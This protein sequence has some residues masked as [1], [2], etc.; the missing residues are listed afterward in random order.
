MSPSGLARRSGLDPTTFNKSKRIAREGKPRWPTTES[1]AKILAATDSTLADFVTLAGGTPA[2]ETVSR[3][4]IFGLAQAASEGRVDA[5]GRPS[6]RGQ[7]EIAF[8]DLNDP[9]AYALEVRGNALAPVYRDA[10]VLVVSPAASVRRGDRVVV[11]TDAGKVMV[12]QLMR[13]T[14]R[15]VD[16]APIPKARPLRSLPTEAVTWMSRIV[17]ASQ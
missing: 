13:K 17:W 10:T 16:L 3:I 5:A 14:A 12:M 1:I 9:N 15:R 8:P 2:A 11:K 4:P 6:G 7:D